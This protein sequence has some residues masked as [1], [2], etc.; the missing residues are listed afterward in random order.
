[1]R[2]VVFL[3]VLRRGCPSPIP[4]GRQSMSM[5]SKKVL[6]VVRSMNRGGVETWL[7]QVLRRIDQQRVKMDF[8]VHTEQNSALDSEILDR[9]C[10]LLRCT[11]AT[12][13]PQYA[14]KVLSLLPQWAGYDIIHSHVHHFSGFVLRLAQRASIPR[15]IA[16]S[17][18]DTSLPDRR[19]RLVRR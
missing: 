7:M 5:K 2:M 18:S 3:S 11:E 16:H 9:G 8:L 6:H 14:S 13:S 12:S 19:S 1:R 15:R 4:D 10:R 17:H